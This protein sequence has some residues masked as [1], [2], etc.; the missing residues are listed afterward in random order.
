MDLRITHERYGSSS[1]RFRS[2]TTASFVTF[3]FYST[4]SRN[5]GSNTVLQ[6]RDVTV[7]QQGYSFLQLV[8]LTHWLVGSKSSLSFLFHIHLTK[9][10]INHCMPRE[11]RVMAC[12]TRVFSCFLLSAS[13]SRMPHA[14]FYLLPAVYCLEYV[15]SAAYFSRTRGSLGLSCAQA[16]SFARTSPHTVRRPVR[17]IRAPPPR[18]RIDPLFLSQFSPLLF[19]PPR[20]PPFFDFHLILVGG[21]CVVVLAS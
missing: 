19:A 17:C 3:P 6:L 10:T 12:M 11:L 16:T 4:S 5:T 15:R 18:V 20:F 21:R 13:G 14:A 1:N 7:L 9:I 8:H 2:G